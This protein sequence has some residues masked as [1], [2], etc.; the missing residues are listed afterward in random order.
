MNNQVLNNIKLCEYIFDNLYFPGKYRFND[1]K[2]L[3]IKKHNTLWNTI[4]YELYY[5]D[6]FMFNL[7]EK[8]MKSYLLKYRNEKLKELLK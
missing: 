2:C 1:K 3:H 6:I 5:N 7:K 4:S 8:E